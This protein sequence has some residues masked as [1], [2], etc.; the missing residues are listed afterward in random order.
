M[1][2]FVDEAFL[3]TFTQYDIWKQ[4]LVFCRLFLEIIKVLS[5]LKFTN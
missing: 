4:V 3:L 2:H 1:I 5:A